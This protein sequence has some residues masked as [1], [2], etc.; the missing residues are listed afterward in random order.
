MAAPSSLPSPTQQRGGGSGSRR[1]GV[2]IMPASRMRGFKDPPYGPP[3]RGNVEDF[4]VS[5]KD[6]TFHSKAIVC[7]DVFV[8]GSPQHIPVGKLDTKNEVLVDRGAGSELVHEHT[9]A[10]NFLSASHIA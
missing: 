3:F 2:L 5:T 6:A 7:L 4:I 9:L 1:C 10:W 8:S